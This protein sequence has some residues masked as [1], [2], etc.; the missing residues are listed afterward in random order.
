MSTFLDRMGAVKADAGG[1]D[2][3]LGLHHPRVILR[4]KRLFFED[5][6]KPWPKSDF[7]NQFG[8]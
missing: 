4:H 7:T 8:E 1:W 5:A 6:S 3:W 2:P